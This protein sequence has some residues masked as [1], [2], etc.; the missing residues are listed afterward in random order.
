MEAGRPSLGTKE[1]KKRLLRMIDDCKSRIEL[2]V[3]RYKTALKNLAKEV[4]RY[5]AAYSKYVKK[6]NERNI[7]LLEDALAAVRKSDSIREDISLRIRTLADTADQA[8]AEVVEIS[9]GLESRAGAGYARAFAKY[10]ESLEKRVHNMERSILDARPGVPRGE[11]TILIDGILAHGMG[12]LDEDYYEDEEYEEEEYEEE[13]AEEEPVQQPAPAQQPVQQPYIP[14]YAPYM[15]PYMPYVQP[16][17]QP[18]VQP[19]QQPTVNVAP[20][21]IN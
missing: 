6:P 18:V 12:D 13:E 1:K 5:D 8:N 17:V 2:E 9:G 15:P 14:Q 4:K 3:K 20:V 7:E 19:A 16:I 21:D 11:A 10:T